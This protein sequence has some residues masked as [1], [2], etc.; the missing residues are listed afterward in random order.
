MG[1]IFT[2][3]V[4]HAA[5]GV[6]VAV[7]ARSSQRGHQDEP[8]ASVAGGPSEVA[9]EPVCPTRMLRSVPG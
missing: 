5:Q 7:S 4:A 2:R 1:P 8:P 9:P 3:G 6:V